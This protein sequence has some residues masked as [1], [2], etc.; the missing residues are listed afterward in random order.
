ME[1][2]DLEMQYKAL[3]EEIEKL[4]ATQIDFSEYVKKEQRTIA[5]N[6][7]KLLIS[8]PDWTI[9]YWSSPIVFSETPKY[10]LT[11][12]SELKEGDVFIKKEYVKNMALE[13]FCI[14]VWKDDNWYYVGQY[15][16]NPCW[17]ELIEWRTLL[18]WEVYKFLRD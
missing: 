7:N 4:K 16:N 15:L 14:F 2:K 6:W 1:L 9:Y 18:D 3:W 5:I 12:L 10:T 11:T 17:I 8:N 13:D